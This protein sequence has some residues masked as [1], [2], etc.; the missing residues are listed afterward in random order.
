MATI[1][2]EYNDKDGEEQGCQ[3]RFESKRK[4]QSFM[5][6]VALGRHDHSF[7]CMTRHTL[8]TNNL[9]LGCEG[10]KNAQKVVSD[11]WALYKTECPDTSASNSALPSTELQMPVLGAGEH[12]PAHVKASSSIESEEE[13]HAKL[14]AYQEQCRKAFD[15]STREHIELRIAFVTES[16]PRRWAGSW[17]LSLSCGNLVASCSSTI[18]W[19]K[20]QLIG[21]SFG[22]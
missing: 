12:T 10:M 8:S 19:S 15:D 2:E 21:T 5:D 17:V 13:Y 18:I 4:L 1:D 9:D 16:S 6:Q 7:T 20:I 14:S 11:I 22:G 3:T